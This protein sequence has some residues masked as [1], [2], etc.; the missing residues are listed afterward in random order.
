[1]NKNIKSI[2]FVLTLV[3]LLIAVGTVSAADNANS[4]TAVENSIS[5]AALSD[6]DYV[7]SEPVTTS[8]DKQVDTKTI[9]KEEKNIKKDPITID[10]NTYEDVFE[11]QEINGEEYYNEKNVFINN[12]T[13]NGEYSGFF[14]TTYINNTIANAPICTE[15]ITCYINNSYLYGGIED[16]WGTTTIYLYNSTVNNTIT[17]GRTT[18]YIYLDDNCVIT[19]GTSI[20]SND[21]YRTIYLITNNTN[22]IYPFTDTFNAE[23]GKLI[24]ITINKNITNNGNLTLNNVTANSTIT[25]NG[26]LII[27][28]NV[29]IGE[30]FAYTGNGKIIINDT[31]KIAPFLKAYNGNYTLINQNITDDKKN[32]GNLTLDNCNIAN[33]ITNQ[34]NLTLNK[35]NVTGNIINEGILIIDNETIFD[36][37]AAITGDGE[38]IVNDLRNIIANIPILNGTYNISDATIDS[39]HIFIGNISFNNCNFISENNSNI[40]YL[41][42]NNCSATN[43]NW[44]NNY[45]ITV[46]NE[47]SNIDE[48]INNQGSIYKGSLPSEDYYPTNYVINNMTAGIF[49]ENNT[50]KDFISP[51]ST[52]DFQGTIGGIPGLTSIIIDRPVNII[53]STNDGR[54][55]NFGNITYNNGASGSNI[56]GLYTYNT[57]FYVRNAHN[58]V[59]DNISNVVVS[60]S[61][62]WGVGQTSI[63]HNSTNITV[64]N[65]YF[66]TKDNGGSST[67]VFGWADNSTLVN[68]TVEADGTVGNL[69]YL[70]TYNVDIPSGVKPNSNN[71][72]LNNTLR[73]PETP[74]GI[75]WGI[76]L[77]G[78]NNTIDG[79]TIYYR[80]TGITGQWGSG[81][82]GN[83]NDEQSLIDIYG[84]TVSNNKLYNGSTI[85]Q[86]NIIYNN[87]VEKGT[88]LVSNAK[89][90]NNTA[91]GLTLGAGQMLVTNNTILGT[92]IVQGGTNREYALIENNTL[93][94]ITFQSKDANNVI[95]NNNTIGSI[96]SGGYPAQ[97]VAVSNITF[98]NNNITS[99]IIMGQ[100]SQNFRYDNNNIIGQITLLANNSIWTNNSIT[101]NIKIGDMFGGNNNQLHYN[102]ITGNI[103]FES[104]YNSNNNTLT[105][106]NINGYIEYKT[107]DKDGGNNNTIIN[108]TIISPQQYTIIVTGNQDMTNN[109]ITDNYLKANGTYGDESVKLN[110]ETNTIANNTPKIELI[111][112]TTEFTP[113]QTTTIKAGIYFDGEILTDITKGKVTFKVDGKTLKDANGKVI[114]AKIINGTATIE[115]Y[116]VPDTWKES[117][118]I[119]AI[120]SGSTQCDKLTSEKTEIT[121]TKEAPT[122][123][124][125]PVEPATAG[126]TITL[127]A[128]ITDNNKVIN[129]GKVVFKINGKTVKDENGKVIYAKVVN[130][131]VSVDYTIPDS[132]KTGNYT[133]TATYMG[134][135]YDRL[136]SESTINVV[137]A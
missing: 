98:T 17:K 115:N 102:N 15:G 5:D 50:L 88:I 2:F 19:P 31:S 51:G 86:G 27:N 94:N 28:D 52:L 14:H 91:A 66:Y 96:T 64:K 135:D 11:N 113:G 131:T 26:K 126:N 6:N 53:T 112:D 101:G 90:Y 32:Y 37:N 71:K 83:I 60:K 10:G 85:L 114:Y 4:T 43:N 120:Y 116:Q 95:F 118:T 77:S 78:I 92:T 45:F 8:N 9:E 80:G 70:T 124:I 12:C 33:S 109:I 123:T 133:L 134:T 18:V 107:T 72:I 82:T 117:S 87:Y 47:E 36:S 7:A 40:G 130:G 127:K 129:T 106:N 13:I 41:Y 3:T 76:V 46:I 57:Q 30:N 34:G 68:S 61:I 100:R 110:K 119:Q 42:L 125:D 21:K 132:Y 74:A 23:D 137:K 122:F 48:T 38:I 20:A 44:L 58:M 128:T 73:G 108:N 89:A 97:D 81:V 67:F 75:C 62:G 121:I 22:S 103:S 16:G 29:I 59:F 104:W 93:N 54:I 1:M 39:N 25:N 55:E 69:I 136:T 111:I 84:N 79:N 99:N 63:G 105:N 56:T 24:D 35:C 49:F 65:S